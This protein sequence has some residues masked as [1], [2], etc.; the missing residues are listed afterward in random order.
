[1]TSLLELKEIRKKI[2]WA[3]RYSDRLILLSDAVFHKMMSIEKEN[4]EYWE[5]Q[6]YILLGIRRDEISLKID[7]LA[8]YGNILSR[9][10]FQQ[11]QD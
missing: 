4:K 1:M 9:R 10:V 11:L 2:T 6:E 5:T 7:I 8:R 3:V